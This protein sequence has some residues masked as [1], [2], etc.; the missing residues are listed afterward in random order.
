M[1]AR[2]RLFPLSLPSS[3]AAA[4]LLALA[5][6]CAGYLLAA[7][8]PPAGAAAG[9]ASAAGQL[10]RSRA[11]ASA[12]RVALS[13]ASYARAVASR[14][15]AVLYRYGTLAKLAWKPFDADASTYLWDLFPPA[16]QCPLA[17]RLGR[18]S[19]GGKWVCNVAALGG[20]SGAAGAH[21]RAGG[22]AGGGA[23]RTSW[24]AG[25]TRSREAS[26]ALQQRTRRGGYGCVVYSF[27]AGMD[28]SFEL[29]VLRR[30]PHCAV[31]MHDPTEERPLPEMAF[32]PAERFAFE[33]V[34]LGTAAGD[35]FG[36]DW[37]ERQCGE[38]GCA[39]ASLEELMARNGHEWLAILK[40]DID[41]NEWSV[42]EALCARPHIP[43]DQILLELHLPLEGGSGEGWRFE[44]GA[45]YI[46]FDR[47]ECLEA[48]GFRVF[49]SELN[50]ANY[51]EG[52]PPFA[53]EL[54]LVRNTSI[55]TTYEPWWDV[56]V[57]VDAGGAD[58]AGD[59]ASLLH[60]WKAPTH[61]L[62]TASDVLARLMALEAGVRTRTGGHPLTYPGVD[63]EALLDEP[64]GGGVRFVG[65]RRLDP[66]TI[67]PRM[68]EFLAG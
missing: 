21:R 30:A 11:A 54:A 66:E 22:A 16:W 31:R 68:G 34:A 49:A 20:L 42:L 19:E 47:L 45:A 15:A 18:A 62:M 52:K 27:G 14:R 41:G 39:A 38:G 44:V 33:R 57:P 64:G 10:R 17:E 60:S 58:P 6:F 23:R 53:S 9:A 46:L 25:P 61:G 29:E 36:G 67:G 5:A 37:L 4:L 24:R 13:E 1:R 8:R 26:E 65:R 3:P 2:R 48:H 35:V 50:H 28:M 51:A 59:T 32:L 40:I 12:S 63:L 43:A 56:A 7:A 55:F